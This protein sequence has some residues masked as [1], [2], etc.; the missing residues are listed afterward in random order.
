MNRQL[1]KKFI[2]YCEGDTEAHYINGFRTWLHDERPDVDVVI[3]PPQNM[4]GGGF[5]TFLQ[6]VKTSPSSNCIA[7][8]VIVDYDR[9]L[10]QPT[11]M[12]AFRKLAEY[13]QAQSRRKAPC[14]LIVSNPDFEVAACFHSERYRNEPPRSFLLHEFGYRSLEEFKS[15]KQVWRTLNESDNGYEHLVT[16]SK[17]CVSVVANDYRLNTSSFSVEVRKMAVNSDADCQKGTNMHDFFDI[18]LWK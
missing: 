15:D 1:R 9:C 17:R 18:V 13:C 7:R 12:T 6:R 4:H 2:V 10:S 16:R 5:S 8:F 3:D 14:L 11:E